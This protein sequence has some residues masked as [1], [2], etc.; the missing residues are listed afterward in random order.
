[1]IAHTQNNHNCEKTKKKILIK[2]LCETK[3]DTGIHG[4]DRIKTNEVSINYSLHTGLLG[5]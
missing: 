2:L 4:I 1:M 3:V 5:F